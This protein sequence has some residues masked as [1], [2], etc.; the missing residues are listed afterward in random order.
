MK[1]SEFKVDPAYPAY[2]PMQTNALPQK[3]RAGFPLAVGILAAVAFVG[4]FGLWSVATQISGAV[5]A[6]GRVEVV[7]KRQVIEHPDGGVVDTIRVKDGDVVKAGDILVGL[8]GTR[9]RSE[10]AIVDGQLRD[11]EARRARYEAERD[12]RDAVTFSPQVEAKAKMYPD[13][14]AQLAGERTLFAARLLSVQQQ[15]DLLAEQTKQIENR[16]TGTEAELK[17]VQAQTVLV[18]SALVDQQTLQRQGLA[19][20][21]RVLDLSRESASQQGQAGQLAA[22]IADLKG[23]IA[24]NGIA[25][26]QLFTKRREDAVSQ[27]ADIQAKQVELLEKQLSLNSTLSLLDIRAPVSGIVYGSKVFAVHSVVRPADPLMYI[28]PQ[29]QPLVVTARVEANHIGELHSGQQVSITFPSFD[30]HLKLP[31]SGTISSISADVMSDETTHQSY[32]SVTVVPD[33]ASL[34]KLVEDKRLVPGMPAEAF[35][36]TGA[37]SPISYLVHP[38]AVYFSR[39]FRD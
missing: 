13:F 31:V 4:G 7:S 21:S 39:A 36:Q 15:S 37:Q 6:P 1:H 34:A 29:D 10:L 2:P 14:A 19:Q 33:T 17:A 20:A 12:G 8:D 27:L 9:T 25:R 16:I 3:W 11:L 26:L 30:Q 35:I 23:Q 22:Q 38:L 28:I 18:A 24:A 32:Y 5:V